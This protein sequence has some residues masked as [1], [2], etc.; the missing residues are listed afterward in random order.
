MAL[1]ESRS[2]NATRTSKTSQETRGATAS[3]LTDMV[4]FL[5]DIRGHVVDKSI[6]PEKEGYISS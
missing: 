4:I 5:A 2:L 6:R 3:K 1:R